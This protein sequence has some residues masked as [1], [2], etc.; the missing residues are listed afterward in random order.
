MASLRLAVTASGHHW[1]LKRWPR[2]PEV[3]LS[4][5]NS[6]RFCSRHARNVLRDVESHHII[7]LTHLVELPDEPSLLGVEG[8]G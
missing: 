1:R 4:A 3:A 6:E 5:M 8:P 7:R 2:S